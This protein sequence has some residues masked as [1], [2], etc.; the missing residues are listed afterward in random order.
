VVRKL[1]VVE[2][3]RPMRDCAPLAALNCASVSF[4]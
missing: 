2:D 4:V 3:V 1:T